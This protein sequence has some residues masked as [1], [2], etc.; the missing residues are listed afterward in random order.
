MRPRPTA[1]RYLGPAEE[2]RLRQALAWARRDP[3][4]TY[5]A[6]IAEFGLS[7]AHVP[8]LRA[9]AEAERTGEAVPRGETPT[10]M[11]AAAW[12][13]H[14]LLKVGIALRDKRPK[15]A[16]D[17]RI[18]EH[19]KRVGEQPTTSLWWPGSKEMET[20]IVSGIREEDLVDGREWFRLSATTIRVVERESGRSLDVLH[21]LLR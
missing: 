13:R 6:A 10:F 1:T 15:A 17:A 12:R 21:R 16:V 8:Y 4:R 9:L 11:Y 3:D 18:D 20:R 14:A 19:A 7:A 5:T 2:A